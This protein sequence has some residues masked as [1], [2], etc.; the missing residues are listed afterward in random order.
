MHEVSI[1]LWLHILIVVVFCIILYSVFV[2]NQLLVVLL[3]RK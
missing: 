3:C 1:R 2:V